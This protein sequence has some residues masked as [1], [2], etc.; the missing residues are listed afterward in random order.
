MIPLTS[1]ESPFLESNGLTGVCTTDSSTLVQCLHRP[2]CNRGRHACANRPLYN[3]VINGTELQRSQITVEGH[4]CTASD[5]WLSIVQPSL[6]R[7]SFESSDKSWKPKDR[8]FR[9]QHSKNKRKL[10][11]DNY[12]SKGH[13]EMTYFILILQVSKPRASEINIFPAHGVRDICRGF[14]HNQL[15]LCLPESVERLQFQCRAIHLAPGP[16]FSHL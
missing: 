15:K 12:G 10:N 6:P 13:L 16:W 8:R 2:C 11:T 9:K 4:T 1:A 7:T 5:G 14:D 3:S